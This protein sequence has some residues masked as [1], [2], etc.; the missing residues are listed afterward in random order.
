MPRGARWDRKVIKKTRVFSPAIY[1]YKYIHM[2]LSRIRPLAR[3]MPVCHLGTM[4]HPVAN[5]ARCAAN[6]L[7]GHSRCG[8]ALAKLKQ[9]PTRAGKLVDV[10][11][12]NKIHHLAVPAGTGYWYRCRAL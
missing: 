8:W 10:W 6:G 7:A 12:L 11:H 9:Q 1:I 3:P 4:D 2:R 5:T